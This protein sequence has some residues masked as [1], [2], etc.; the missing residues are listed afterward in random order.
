MA[1]DDTSLIR[2]VDHSVAA[3]RQAA[4]A[5]DQRD[6]R[7]VVVIVIVVLDLARRPLQLHRPV[8]DALARGRFRGE[9]EALQ[10][11]CDG[12]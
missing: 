1:T 8:E 10:T 2:R 5:G 3:D 12:R 6:Q 11:A 9:A 7:D 4:G